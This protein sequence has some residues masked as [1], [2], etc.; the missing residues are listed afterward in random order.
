MSQRKVVLFLALAVSLAVYITKT[1]NYEVKVE[2]R[3]LVKSGLSVQEKQDSFS[4][5]SPDLYSVVRVVDGDTIVVSVGNKDEKVRLVGINTPETVDPRKVVECFG[6]E[7]SE[8][9]KSLLEGNQ[10]LLKSDSSQSDRDRYGR[11][12]RYVYLLDGSFINLTLVEQGYAYEYTYH[13][14]YKF[15]KE[16]KKAE[17]DARVNKRGLWADGAC[18][19]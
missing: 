16:F 14:P 7:A 13:V 5:P 19:V 8:K 11:L 6:K 4:K 1:S 18:N 17:I 10:V 12:L 15:Q 3:E 9:I 2:K